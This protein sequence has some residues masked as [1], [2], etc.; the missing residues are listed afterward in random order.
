MKTKLKQI[1]I[2][3]PIYQQSVLAYCDY[4]SAHRLLSK[5]IIKLLQ[6]EMQKRERGASAQTPPQQESFLGD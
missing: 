1:K 3:I 5:V 6:E 4:L 2:N